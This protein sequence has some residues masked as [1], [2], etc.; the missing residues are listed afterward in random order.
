MKIFYV[1]NDYDA[2]LPDGGALEL[3]SIEQDSVMPQAKNSFPKG[4]SSHIQSTESGDSRLAPDSRPCI[5]DD[6]KSSTAAAQWTEN[7]RAHPT[8]F[9][10]GGFC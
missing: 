5:S 7:P 4:T 10:P 2:G 1:Y 8:Y 3:G 6:H 9:G